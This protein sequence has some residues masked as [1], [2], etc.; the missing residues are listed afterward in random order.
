MGCRA[1]VSGG[2]RYKDG[3]IAVGEG[4]WLPWYVTWEFSTEDGRIYETTKE[5]GSTTGD[6]YSDIWAWDLM[7]CHQRARRIYMLTNLRLPAT[8]DSPPATSAAAPDAPRAKN[9]FAMAKPVSLVTAHK[10]TFRAV[11]PVFAAH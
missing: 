10:H 9:L 3:T 11:R 4:G 5:E 8:K 2:R 6:R 7:N 1:A